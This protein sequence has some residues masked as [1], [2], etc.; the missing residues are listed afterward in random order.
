MTTIP[1]GCECHYTSVSIPGEPHI[2]SYLEAEPNPNC[3]V[4]PM[5]VAADDSS[6]APDIK[7]GE[8]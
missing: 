2:P 7:E 1:D 4:H 5:T 6:S 3:P 8:F